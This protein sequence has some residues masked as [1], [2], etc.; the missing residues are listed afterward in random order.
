MEKNCSFGLINTYQFCWFS[1]ETD[2]GY[3]WGQLLNSFCLLIRCCQFLP[4]RFRLPNGWVCFEYFCAL[5]E[6]HQA[7]LEGKKKQTKNSIMHSRLLWSAYTHVIVVN[8]IKM[9]LINLN[10]AINDVAKV[11]KWEY[12]FFSVK[13][14][15]TLLLVT[16]WLL[17]FKGF[18]LFCF[19]FC[20]LSFR[21]TIVLWCLFMFP[22]SH[23]TLCRWMLSITMMNKCL[24]TFIRM[25][26]EL[27]ND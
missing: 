19:S 13:D 8:S 17:L 20:F 6:S 22:F 16:L 18:L 15:W 12:F 14:L 5:C 23:W 10:E 11:P 21:G 27:T 7:K 4:S 1:F 3:V 9:E 25:F 26:F 2:S 24:Q